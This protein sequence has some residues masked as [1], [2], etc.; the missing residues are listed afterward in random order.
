MSVT[1]ISLISSAVGST[2]A[3]L[4]VFRQGVKAL[5][6]DEASSLHALHTS[7]LA[8]IEGTPHASS[9]RRSTAASPLRGCLGAVRT[10]AESQSVSLGAALRNLVAEARR[11]DLGLW[12][13][14]ARAWVLRS[15]DKTLRD[16]A[17]TCLAAIQP[18]KA[19]DLKNSPAAPRDRLLRFSAHYSTT[20]PF[21]WPWRWHAMPRCTLPPAYSRY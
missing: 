18:P 17:R 11:E 3:L 9:G 12:R 15:P 4:S 13:I 1:N 16:A 10:L 14:A 6:W 7:L 8:L 2:G 21:G 20:A 5:P 19:P